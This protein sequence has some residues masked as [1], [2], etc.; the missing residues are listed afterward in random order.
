MASKLGPEEYVQF[1]GKRKLSREETQPH[2][3]GRLEKGGRKAGGLSG[4]VFGTLSW[5]L[6][7]K[8]SSLKKDDMVVSQTDLPEGKL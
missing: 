7:G 4:E 3:A 8:Q 2:A 5:G 6:W 1:G